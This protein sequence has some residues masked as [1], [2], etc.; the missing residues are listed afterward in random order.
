MC[1]Q[2]GLCFFV[3]CKLLISGEFCL[4][5]F[6]YEMSV[7]VLQERR[8]E[9]HM[10][11][12]LKK[13]VRIKAL[14][15]ALVFS[16]SIVMP[17]FA[18]AAE[19]YDYTPAT[20]AEVT[21][22][23]APSNDADGA[24]D[25]APANDGANDAAPANDGATKS[26]DEK[27]EIVN[28]RGARVVAAAAAGEVGITPF[29]TGV[30]FILTVFNPDGSVLPINVTVDR[31][32]LD[33][34]AHNHYRIQPG[35]DLGSG[36]AFADG[37]LR[38]II[39]GVLDNPNTVTT[40][41]G[42]VVRGVFLD[43]PPP[44]K[45]VTF[46][47]T[48]INPDG[49]VLPI[50]VTVEMANLE[51]AGHNYFRIASGT[52]LSGNPF[53]DGLLIAIINGVLDNPDTETT[54]A[55][56][57]L[58]GKLDE[59]P[60]PPPRDI[61]FDLTVIN[62]DGS[63]LPINIVIS[64]DN[65]T[66]NAHNHF[67]INPGTVI[68]GNPFAD[69]LLIAIINGVLDNPDTETDFDED[70]G[71]LSGILDETPP[72]T[73]RAYFYNVADGVSTRV[74]Y[75]APVDWTAATA[76]TIDDITIP[77]GLP[78][79]GWV[80]GPYSIEQIDGNWV[81]TV[82]FIPA[83]PTRVIAF[84]DYCVG[85]IPGTAA[86]CSARG[87]WYVYIEYGQSVSMQAVL[88]FIYQQDG[89]TGQGFGAPVFKNAITGELFPAGLAYLPWDQIP[90]DEDGVPWI[91]V[92]FPML[93][94]PQPPPVPCEVCETYPCEC[95]ETETDETERPDPRD[96]TTRRPAEGPKTGDTNNF[97]AQMAVMAFVVMTIAV[98]GLIR[99][100]EQS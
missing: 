96:P 44:T 33:A 24:N 82:N 9:N 41:D 28:E 60:P 27:G 38:A 74:G 98:T 59:T 20:N 35:A 61:T 17:V 14:L 73:L 5:K 80:L 67:R 49:S 69:G 58:Q 88:D 8:E 22:P 19:L 18:T 29:T 81:I 85:T 10:E 53:A 13:S 30:T 100:R 63:V 87:G 4:G 34:N 26:A 89:F 48:V 55:N 68:S 15:L 66:P 50:N 79:E 45:E 32:D 75:L 43:N 76:P 78:A 77:A 6:Q 2:K 86:N 94:T 93:E 47:L 7:E 39:N 36:N 54:F 23:E 72:P 25:A 70:T 97:F 42:N 90:I 37:L 62:P 16:L 95:E 3:S 21:V 46:D 31:D 84:L 99:T 71:I 12:R 11:T 92:F 65:L 83:Q 91:T 1:E 40:Y 56:G 57:V 52:V 51:P 64:E